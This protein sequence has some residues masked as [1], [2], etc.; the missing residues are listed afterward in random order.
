MKRIQQIATSL[1]PLALIVIGGCSSTP[2]VDARLGRAVTS[3]VGAETLNLAASMNRV[4]V[5]GLE[6]GASMAVVARYTRSFSAP[7]PP[8]NVFSIGVGTGTSTSAV[9]P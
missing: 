8:A 7:P 6:A 3:A 5:A 2:V 4:P 1:V 9:A